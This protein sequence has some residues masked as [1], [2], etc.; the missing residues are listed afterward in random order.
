MELRPE[1]AYATAVKS[2]ETITITATTEDNFLF[3]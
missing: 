2:A 3:I 1:Q